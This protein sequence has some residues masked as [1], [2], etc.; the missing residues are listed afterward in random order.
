MAI[1]ASEIGNFLINP[2]M[3]KK[4]KKKSSI[5]FLKKNIRTVK[6][7]EE[8]ICLFNYFCHIT[9]SASATVAC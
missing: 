3:K 8:V 1:G 2:H 5:C 7:K 9:N 4:K 6:I